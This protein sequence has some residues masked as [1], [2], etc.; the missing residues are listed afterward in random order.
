MKDP[1]KRVEEIVEE[2]MTEFE[3]ELAQAILTALEYRGFYDCGKYL[4][5]SLIEHIRPLLAQLE[6]EVREQIKKE[7]EHD[8][9]KLLDGFG[10]PKDCEMCKTLTRK[11]H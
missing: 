6:E 11:D 8:Q 3:R 9:Q 1:Q 7:E 2:D 4:D 5:T 10:H